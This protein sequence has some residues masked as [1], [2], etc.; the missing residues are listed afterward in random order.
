MNTAI[1]LAGGS[2]QRFGGI[3]PKQFRD[4][5]GRAVIDHS[6]QTFADNETIDSVIIVVPG[7]WL[8]RLQDQYSQHVVITGGRSRRE[9]S[10]IGLSACPENSEFVFIHDAARALV[11]DDIIQRCLDG[12]RLSKAVTAVWPI[13][14]TIAEVEKEFISCMPKREL[15]YALQTPQAFQYNTILQAHKT[16]EE[17][18]TDDIRLVMEMGEECLIVAGAENN[19]KITTELDL[20]LAEVV[21]SGDSL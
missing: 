5:C 14:D 13:Q 21:L 4:L 8:K 16:I 20:K 7:D 17:E 12:L 19:F 10:W 1:I 18:T 6:I 9:S 3:I 2:S 15:L 11:S